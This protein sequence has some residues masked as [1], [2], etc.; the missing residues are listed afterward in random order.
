MHVVILIKINYRLLG[1]G[2]DTSKTGPVP[3]WDPTSD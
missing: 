3:F 2:V 1:E